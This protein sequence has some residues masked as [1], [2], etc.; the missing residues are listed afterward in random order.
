MADVF[1]I[2]GLPAYTVDWQHLACLMHALRQTGNGIRK[3]DAITFIRSEGYLDLTAED[4]APYRSQSE[5]SWNTDIAYSR[6]IGLIMGLVSQEG[7]DSWGLTSEGI[8]KID[9]LLN[10]TS[11]SKFN[12][13][14]CFLWSK[15]LKR[16]FDPAYSPSPSDL[17]RPAKIYRSFSE[18]LCLAW[19]KQQIDK[20]EGRSAARFLSEKLGFEVY[21]EL[22]SLA[23]AQA[24]YHDRGLTYSGF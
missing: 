15:T 11:T 8:S 12:A 19:A 14:A 3:R 20:D 5:P 7:R 22:Y 24:L 21:R 9:Y 10:A 4:N 18:G 6:K 17:P 13:G 23:H 1:D 2:N 16:V